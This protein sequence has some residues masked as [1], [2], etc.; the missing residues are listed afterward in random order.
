MLETRLRDLLRSARDE[1]QTQGIQAEFSFHRERSSLI[2][3]GNSS[4]ALST[5]EE[6]T[7][8]DVGVTDGKRTGSFTLL[9]DLTSREQVLDAVRRAQEHCAASLEKEYEPIFGVVE[10]TVDDVNGFDPEL[11]NLSPVAK[12]GL[13]AEVIQAIKPRGD[14]DFSGSWTSGSTE[15]YYLTTAN[16][17]EA[18]RRL[19]DGRLFLVLKEQAQKWELSVEQAGKSVGAF[20]AAD[21]IAEFEQLLPIYTQQG[22]Y[23]APLGYTRVLFGQQA[24]AEL[25]GLA[26]WG[27]FLGRGWEEKRA[28]TAGKQFGDVLFSPNVTIIDDP[29]HAQV[30]GMPFDF[31]GKR[32]RP[33]PLVEAGIFKGLMYGTTSAARYGKAPTG[34]DLQNVDMV[35][36]TGQ[37]PAGL[38]AGKA[39]AGDALYIPHLHYIHM[40]NPSRGQFTGSSRFNAQRLEG[41]ACTAPLFSTRI[42]DTIPNVLSHVIAISSRAVLVDVSNTYERRTPT[43]VSVP[44]YLLCDNVRISDVAESF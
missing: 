9:A 28:Y 22:G 14:Y 25:V 38:D 39:L 35:F 29:T 33:F 23:R 3:L 21:A 42:T 44:E 31:N 2:R 1:A 13:C 15:Y 36:R 18:Y 32:R 12:A 10:E 16:E 19:T 34:H 17:H 11:E 7:R 43:A 26:M 24:V 5:S 37:A 27:G 8:L 40:P 41:G 4:V 30:Y 20:S 6:L